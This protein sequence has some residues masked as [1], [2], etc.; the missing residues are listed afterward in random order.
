MAAKR[1]RQATVAG[2]CYPQDAQ[3]LRQTLRELI[4]LAVAKRAAVGV[5][6]PHACYQLSGS[7]IGET[8]SRVAIPSI[9]VVLAPNH[10]GIGPSWSLMTEGAYQT[11]LGE[12][13]IHES[14]AHAWREACPLLSADHTV[15]QVEH[16]IEVELPFLQWLGPQDLAI[17]PVII[18]AEDAQAC[19]HVAEALAQVIRQTREPV[20]LIASSEL[21]HYEPQQVAAQSDAQL[22]EALQALD[23]RRFREQ[24]EASQLITCSAGPVSC[25]IMASTKLGASQANLVRYQTSADA[26]GDPDSVI[27]YAGMILN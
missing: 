12:V 11:P 15:H 27:G 9:C 4:P 18:N 7:I 26:G 3:T 6:V 1:I 17:V 24:A 10:T 21:T 22:L 19:E 16:A 13:P 25:L 23:V 8:L 14:F 2:Y 20:L 5:L